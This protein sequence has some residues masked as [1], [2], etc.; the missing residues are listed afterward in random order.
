[1]SSG[2][3]FS[4]IETP[5]SGMRAERRRMQVISTNIAN[6]NT[7]DENG[8]PYQRKSVIFEEVLSGRLNGEAGPDGM[9]GEASGGVR[10][11]KIVTDTTSEHPRI[12]DPSHPS[13]GEDGFV[14]MPNVNVMF[15]MVDLMV[16]R[17]AYGAN[18]AAFRNYRA[19][20]KEAIQN[21]GAR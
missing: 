19:M 10:A 4:G 16:A 13:A 8:N 18:I 20:V 21:I 5:I 2:G 11:D 7:I 6:A 1:M 3:L 12:Y 9:L 17:R 15:E 14:R